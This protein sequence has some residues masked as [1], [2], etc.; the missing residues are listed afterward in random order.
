MTFSETC[1]SEVEEIDTTIRKVCTVRDGK[2]VRLESIG[3]VAVIAKHNAM[4]QFCRRV[5]ND[6]HFDEQERDEIVTL[7][8]RLLLEMSSDKEKSR[9]GEYYERYLT[10]LMHAA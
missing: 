10:T 6:P 3:L 4:I 1:N 7:L 8:N 9:L 5:H 2:H